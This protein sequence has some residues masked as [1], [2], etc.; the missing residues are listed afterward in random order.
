MIATSAPDAAIR[1]FRMEFDQR[2]GR[3]L[4]DERG[5]RA[6]GECKT[7]FHLSP[8]VRRQIDRNERSEPRL[9]IGDKEIDQV[10]RTVGAGPQESN[11]SYH[12]LKV[13]SGPYSPA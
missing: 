8:F 4:A 3:Q 6:Q 9:H 13:T 10:E 2:P 11:A 7:N 1:L 5:H 12:A